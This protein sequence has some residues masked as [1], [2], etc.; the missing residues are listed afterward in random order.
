MSKSKIEVAANTFSMENTIKT[1]GFAI[2]NSDPA[3]WGFRYNL[4]KGLVKQIPLGEVIDQQLTIDSIAVYTF[5]SDKTDPES[6]LRH[7]LLLIT[8]DMKVYRTSSEHLF[9][10]TV[11][12]CRMS[13]ND[14][15]DFRAM[16]L[17]IVVRRKELDGGKTMYDMEVVD[18]SAQVN[19]T[20]NEEKVSL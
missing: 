13:L 14:Y 9:Y 2:S 12:M 16:P 19:N 1:V 7:T 8:P 4:S 15:A 11:D 18:L 17:T 10:Q 20:V 6:K 5:H 3:K